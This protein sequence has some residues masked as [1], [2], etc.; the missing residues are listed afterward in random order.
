MVF[1]KDMWEYLRRKNNLDDTNCTLYDG[2]TPGK[3]VFHVFLKILQIFLSNIPSELHNFV[4]RVSIN[5]PSVPRI[6]TGTASSG[7]GMGRTYSSVCNL[8]S[9]GLVLARAAMHPD[10][11]FVKYIEN[12]MQDLGRPSLRMEERPISFAPFFNFN[13]YIYII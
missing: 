8:G 11:T 13:L 5:F 1:I 3:T 9:L 2:S 4:V 10:T 6:V 7:S 12:K